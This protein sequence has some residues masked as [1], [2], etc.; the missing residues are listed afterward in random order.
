MTNIIMNRKELEQVKIFEKLLT[1]SITQNDAATTLGISNRQVRRKLKKYRLLGAASLAHQ[2]RGKPSK[3]VWNKEEKEFAMKLFENEFNGFGPTFA[4]EKLMDLYNIKISNETLRQ[5]M[6]KSGVWIK[7]IKRSKHRTRR[8]RS[9]CFGMMIQLDGSP[10]DWFKGRA[11]KCTLLVF[12]DDA[13]SKILWLEFVPSESV[14]SLMNATK[15][16]ILKWGIPIYF[17]TD[18]GSVFHVN[19]NNKDHEKL[20]QFERSVKELG[21]NIIHASSP[22]AKGRVERANKTLQDRLVKEMTLREI[23]GMDDA[24]AFAQNEYLTMHNNKF[25]VTPAE[26]ID[27]H[28][29]P[30]GFN[31]NDIFCLKD[32]RI[33]QNDFTVKYKN[34]LFQLEKE[35]KTLV[36][37]KEFAS[38]F[39]SFD[40]TISMLLRSTK[41]NFHKIVDC[42]EFKS[43]P[44]DCAVK[45][46]S[47]KIY[48]TAKNHPWRRTN[49]YLFKH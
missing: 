19:I 7:E 21:A 3:R 23:S 27:V 13:T 39:E 10:H 40:G 16:Y 45:S 41:L 48:T 14:E 20:T 1:Q 36:R 5:A 17:Y 8:P 30:L 44:S 43:S 38:I 24:N 6:I 11:P 4:T 2:N 32:S 33:I 47:F 28:K 35:Q 31:L 29:S 49:N 34:Q 18:Y 25:A 9:A 22:Q 15:N 12:I 42:R 37:P 26:E 46:G